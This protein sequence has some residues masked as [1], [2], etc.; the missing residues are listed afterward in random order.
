MHTAKFTYNI[1][2]VSYSNTRKLCVDSGTPDFGF[3]KYID[4][5]MWVQQLWE[6]M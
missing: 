6:K 3:A 1:F 5:A 2:Q 4:I